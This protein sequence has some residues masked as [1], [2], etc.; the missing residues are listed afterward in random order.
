M[1]SVW[2]KKMNK[3]YLLIILL[4]V[5]VSFVPNL[6]SAEVTFWQDKQVKFN[7]SGLIQ[8]HL[9]FYY[10]KS[11]NDFIKGNNPLDAYII[12]EIFFYSY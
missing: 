2:R 5:I 3:F 6:A 4:A 7:A 10:K 12:Y 9:V 1:K 8:N 11:T